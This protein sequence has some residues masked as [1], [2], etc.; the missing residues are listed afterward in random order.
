MQKAR[1]RYF[2]KLAAEP[3]HK[4]FCN[5]LLLGGFINPLDALVHLDE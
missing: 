5:L 4:K 3:R 2:C 1:F